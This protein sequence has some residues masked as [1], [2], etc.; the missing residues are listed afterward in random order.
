MFPLMVV[1]PGCCLFFLEW[2]MKL[3]FPDYFKTITKK[4]EKVHSSV[5]FWWTRTSANWLCF[6]EKRRCYRTHPFHRRENGTAPLRRLRSRTTVLLLSAGLGAGLA[7]LSSVTCLQKWEMNSNS[8]MGFVEG[9]M[10]I[11]LSSISNPFIVF[12]ND[13]VGQPFGGR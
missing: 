11:K 5:I 2:T 4:T 7:Y 12:F 8:L 10:G 9:K 1:K 6:F 13:Y 3:I